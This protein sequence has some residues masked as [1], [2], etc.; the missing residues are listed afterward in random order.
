MS[1]LATFLDTNARALL[2]FVPALRDGRVDAV[3]D[4]RV[5]TRRLRAALGILESLGPHPHLA[6]AR[7]LARRASRALGRVRDLDVG[8]ELLGDLERRAP[9]AAPAAAL[10]RRQMQRA[11]T[12]A[13]RKLV[14][15]LDDLP[16]HRLPALVG[17]TLPALGPA[18][19][20]QARERAGRV[21]GA[22]DRA[23]GVY[24]P[25]RA[26]GARIEIKKLRYLIEFHDP[27]DVEALKV[28]RQ[29]QAILGDIQDRQVVHGMVAGIADAKAP[30]LDLAPLLDLLEAECDV[31]YDRFIERRAALVAV[32]GRLASPPRRPAM[33]ARTLL[34][35]GAV[36]AGAAL[37]IWRFRTAS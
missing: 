34:A 1:P 13:R 4:A 36:V 20:A 3:H 10:C 22:I 6:E 23:S 15:K 12:A 17:G 2:T 31:L 26:H 16:L 29:S 24:F 30:E 25:R 37:P 27:S 32:C 33:P 5:A 11:R 28:L 9:S 14:R 8:L 35:A 18:L 19:A 7:A 21:L